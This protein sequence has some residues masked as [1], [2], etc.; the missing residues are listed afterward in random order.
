MMVR[1]TMGTR[2]GGQIGKD[3]KE[4]EEVEDD[5]KEEKEER[6]EGMIT[7]NAV[8]AIELMRGNV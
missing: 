2:M 8:A 3:R 5:D 6:E 7:S 4:G 1:E